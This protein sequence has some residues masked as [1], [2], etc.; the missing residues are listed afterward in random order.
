MGPWKKY[1]V[2]S[3]LKSLVLCYALVYVQ[4]LKLI[5]FPYSPSEC[6]MQAVR[7]YDPTLRTSPYAF[8]TETRTHVLDTHLIENAH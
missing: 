6:H 8:E 1:S 2:C 4:H 3:G 5:F 7:F